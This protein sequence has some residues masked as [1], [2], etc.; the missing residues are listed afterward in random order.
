MQIHEDGRHVLKISGA[1]TWLAQH[2]SINAWYCI[3]QR[4]KNGREG[5]PASNNTYQ[6]PHVTQSFVVD[7]AAP[8]TRSE[9]VDGGLGD[10][11]RAEA[12][13]Q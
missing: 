4:E 7:K 12:H 13:P 10:C 9:R 11:A 3:S 6:K 1:A 2:R 5:I 8:H